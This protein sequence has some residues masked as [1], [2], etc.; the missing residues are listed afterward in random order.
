MTSYTFTENNSN[1]TFNQ[2]ENEI[3]Y[4]FTINEL[5]SKDLVISGS[6]NTI[7]G[8][9]GTVVLT[10]DDIEE[11]IS[12]LYLTT[13]ERNKLSGIETSATA[14][15][16]AEEIK[17]LLET[18]E[19]DNRLDSS[20]IKNLGSGSGTLTSVG[21]TGSEFTI[22]NSPITS[23][24]NI[25]LSISSISSTKVSGL[26]IVA[27]SND[28][29]DLDNLPSIPTLISELINDSGFTTTSTSL[30]S[31]SG[32]LSNTRITGLTYFATGTDASNLTGTIN[33]SRLA[34][35][36]TLSGNT[37]NGNSQLIQL[38]AAGKY[39]ALD[40]SLITNL[41]SG[42]VPSGNTFP[43]SPL[44]G[45]LFLQNTT[46]RKWLYEYV[47][48]DWQAIIQ[49]GDATI[50]VAPHATGSQV[51]TQGISSGT[52]LS[53]Q[54]ISTRLP[55]VIN[56]NLTIICASGDY[57]SDVINI[58]NY[59][60]SQ[61]NCFIKIYG[62]ITNLLTSRTVSSVNA[63]RNIITFTTNVGVATAKLHWLR[64]SSSPVPGTSIGGLYTGE[65]YDSTVVPVFSSSGTTITIPA[66]DDSMF[67]NNSNWD[68]YSCNS[69][70]NG[71]T[72]FNIVNQNNVKLYNLVFNLTG[73]TILRSNNTNNI[74][75]SG[76]YFTMYS[77]SSRYEPY[78]G[79][80]INYFG[81]LFDNTGGSNV[82]A[83]FRSVGALNPNY[84]LF[85]WVINNHTSS[86]SYSS[87]FSGSNRTILYSNR[88]EAGS[89]AHCI[90]VSRGWVFT[91]GTLGNNNY[92][93]G[94][95]GNSA[96]RADKF[97]L[98]ENVANTG[99]VISGLTS[100]ASTD[101]STY[102]ITN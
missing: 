25:S 44:E 52:S 87:Q 28:Y 37:F 91:L 21:I 69:L 57:S 76:C 53:F 58:S 97:G 63:A 13:S 22:T 4:N 14:D 50:Y 101:T 85:N 71:T 89:S 93:A 3:V 77:S 49:Y 90:L 1:Y 29:L 23:S 54:F 66:T 59:T 48:S 74:L 31:F 40:G 15:Q 67:S 19:N 41:K 35:E 16:T 82:Q 46:G 65:H 62:S 96:V 72:G 75:V 99:H 79:F 94:S 98:A 43:T 10:S 80:N 100:R 92:F 34:S 33:N 56:G 84:F 32:N 8:Y 36:V 6:V 51:L 27:T 11:G 7:N 9:S 18:L 88:F 78:D 47:N 24:G 39:P 68:V 20:A 61:A 64:P 5:V 30:S 17:T 12:N 42:D 70:F 45:D 83:T 38:T 73:V 60:I 26:S 81:C 86:G 95:S 55:K 2:S 102:G